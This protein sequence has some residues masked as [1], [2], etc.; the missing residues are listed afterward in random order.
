[1]RKNFFCHYRPRF[2]LAYYAATFDFCDTDEMRRIY[3]ALSQAWKWAHPEL[4]KA[5]NKDD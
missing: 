3:A 4:F 5:K 1:M 2:N